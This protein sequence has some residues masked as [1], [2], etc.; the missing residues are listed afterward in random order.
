MHSQQGSSA[1]HSSGGTTTMA[2]TSEVGGTTSN[3]GTAATGGSFVTGG[4]S[5]TG[6]TVSSGGTKN[7]GGASSSGGTT[8][9]GGTSSTGGTTTTGGTSSTGGTKNTGGTTASGGTTTTGG[10]SAN[11]GTTTTGG[12]SANGGTTTAC[13]QQLLKNPNF[14]LGLTDWTYI[15]NEPL[16]T[17]EGTKNNNF[18]PYG[19]QSSPYYIRMGW[20][21]YAAE[22][23]MQAVSI[24]SN[25]AGAKLTFCYQIETS[26][27]RTDPVDKFFVELVDGSSTPQPAPTVLATLSNANATT[28]GDKKTRDDWNYVEYDVSADWAGKT[29]IVR[30]RDE[31]D[32]NLSTNLYLD[33]V[34]LCV[35]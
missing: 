28:Y 33:T 16:L 34:Q 35:P 31:L 18:P 27:T 9:T 30:F 1:G 5:S 4:V 12:A 29:M 22:T 25:F 14:E 32:Q 10:A 23:L 13:R 2:G 26:E 20:Y 7:T 19:A 11:G 24:P 6:G 17:D 8:A 3:G 15:S 21:R